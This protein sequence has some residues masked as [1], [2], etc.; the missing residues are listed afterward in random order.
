[1]KKK[2]LLDLTGTLVALVTLL[3][4][5]GC[6]VLSGVDGLEVG[7]DPETDTQRTSLPQD[8]GAAPDGGEAQASDGSASTSTASPGIPRAPLECD[9]HSC[10]GST[11]HCC[12]KPNARASCV[13]VDEPCAGAR[14]T[15]DGPGDCGSGEVCCALAVTNVAQCVLAAGCSAVG[16]VMCNSDSEC[17]ASQRC[18]AKLE[19]FEHQ[20]CE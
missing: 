2:V 19:S 5:A 12:R 11:P 4:A 14:I 8:R 15:C 10:T 16:R 1:M 20:A 18:T 17:E 9:G 6:N 3:G 13:G 7:A